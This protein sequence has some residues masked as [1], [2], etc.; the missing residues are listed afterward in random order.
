MAG[1]K[2]EGRQEDNTGQRSLR[3]GVKAV[4]QRSCGGRD[5]HPS[6]RRGRQRPAEVTDNS[7]F[8]GALHQALFFC[9]FIKL[10][11]V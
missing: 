5:Q 10:I 2:E 3:T 4:P 7:E 1:G 11:N 6:Q 8:F 9:L